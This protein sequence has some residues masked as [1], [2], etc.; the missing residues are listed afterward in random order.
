MISN[1]IQPGASNAL[2]LLTRN[3]Q[4][5]PKTSAVAPTNAGTVQG[6]SGSGLG[7]LAS[8][9]RAFEVA[10]GRTPAGSGDAFQVRL[11]QSLASTAAFL[12]SLSEQ[13]GGAPVVAV[14]AQGDGA[15]MNGAALA[16]TPE[17][18][19]PA[20][21]ASA[22]E[23]MRK[24][25][26]EPAPAAT[27][28]RRA[29]GTTGAD[30]I[31]LSTAGK[32]DDVLA[33]A[34]EDA[35]NVEGSRVRRVLGG[36]GNDRITVNGDTVRSVGGGADD[37]RIRVSGE[38]VGAVNG[39]RG[40]DRVSVAAAGVG[41]VK[42]GVGRDRLDVTAE[43][44]GRV[45]GGRDSDQIRVRATT[46][47]EV[48]GGHGNDRIDVTAAAAGRVSGGDGDDSIRVEAMTAEIDGGRGDDSIKLNVEAARMKFAAGDGNDRVRLGL[49]TTLLL[50][51]GAGL[52]RD[53]LT[54]ESVGDDDRQLM[55]KFATGESVLLDRVHIASSIA[56]SFA[57]G[58]IVTLRGA[59]AAE[60]A[61]SS[62]DAK[63]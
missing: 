2:N 12:R 42:G 55:L 15:E 45:D 18:D 27:T 43:S 54:V 36:D 57:D 51:F 34:G 20:S 32:I 40:N 44:V 23:P 47:D 29:E 13:L 60:Q 6:S 35:V 11:Q 37:D 10:A 52:T 61:G 33:G 50:D 19:V 46:V 14:A 62:F 8:I 26:P 25:E 9:I 49:G 39:D 5:K 7:R 21:E 28:P 38:N 3:A 17:P 30:T 56:L 24:P 16:P 1:R 4:N 48:D 58:E 41:V 31:A 63:A 22:P 53:S 59:P